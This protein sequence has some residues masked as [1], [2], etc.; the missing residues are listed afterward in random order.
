MLRSLLLPLLVLAAPVSQS[1]LD[2]LHSLEQ[3]VSRLEAEGNTGKYYEKVKAEIARIK[4]EYGLSA[5]AGAG[6]AAKSEVPKEDR[7]REEARAQAQGEKPA[8]SSADWQRKKDDFTR[9]AEEELKRR[10]QA[11]P[12]N[13]S[14]FYANR[15]EWQKVYDAQMQFAQ[16]RVAAGGLGFDFQ[17]ADAWVK[18]QMESIG[19]AQ[20]SAHRQ[21]Y[22]KAAFYL[23]APAAKG[24]PGYVRGY[25]RK[26]A[27]ELADKTDSELDKWIAQDKARRASARSSS[28]FARFKQSCEGW[29]RAFG[30]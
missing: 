24:G 18:G 9:A 11:K 12:E 5:G 17:E 13:F 29:F 16:G 22:A 1:T 10:Q 6:A 26:L 21:R 28:G 7:A 4:K 23:Q 25:A 15:A 2:H 3:T 19:P 14:Q 8:A 27:L 20:I 30:S